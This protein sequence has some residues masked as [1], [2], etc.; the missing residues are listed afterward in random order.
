MHNLHCSFLRPLGTQKIA[1]R[2]SNTE[3][4]YGLRLEGVLSLL[5]WDPGHQVCPSEKKHT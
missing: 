1:K 4:V 2:L 3:R 5:V